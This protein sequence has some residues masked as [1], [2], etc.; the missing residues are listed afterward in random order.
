MLGYLVN[1]VLLL[2]VTLRMAF[3][4]AKYFLIAITIIIQFRTIMGANIIQGACRQT[5]WLKRLLEITHPKASPFTC[6][7]SRLK[8]RGLYRTRM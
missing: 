1:G 4:H 7:I 2:L 6:N 3:H 8:N 5:C